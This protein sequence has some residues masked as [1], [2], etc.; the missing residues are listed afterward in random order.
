MSSHETREAGGCMCSVCHTPGS[1]GRNK[2]MF[3][4]NITREATVVLCEETCISPN[5]KPTNRNIA[6]RKGD[7]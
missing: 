6:K 4:L 2:N 3:F 7:A 5:I 1:E